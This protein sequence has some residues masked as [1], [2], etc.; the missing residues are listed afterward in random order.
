MSPPAGCTKPER[1]SGST[2]KIPTAKPRE[3]TMLPIS[4]PRP[5]WMSSPSAAIAAE[6]MS[7]RVP[8][9]RVSY[10]TKTP[11]TKGVLTQRPRESAGGAARRR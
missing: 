1:K 3:T 6:R 4:V 2:K 11:R 10:R 5:I 7:I 8:R 9:T